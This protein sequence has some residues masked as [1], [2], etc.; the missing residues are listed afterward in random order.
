MAGDVVQTVH[1]NGGRFLR[2]QE[3][4]FWIEVPIEDA[5]AKAS[6]AL[7]ED[8]QT[9][10]KNVAVKVSNTVK[11]Q[12][13]RGNTLNDYLHAPQETAQRMAYSVLDGQ[14][15]AKHNIVTP[16]TTAIARPLQSN[17]KQPNHAEGI[18]LLPL[19]LNGIQEGVHVEHSRH[20]GTS[21]QWHVQELSWQEPPNSSNAEAKPE[22]CEQ[23][24]HAQASNFDRQD[25]DSQGSQ[26]SRD[27]LVPGGASRVGKHE[28]VAQESDAKDMS[29]SWEPPPNGVVGIVDRL[30]GVTPES[31]PRPLPTCGEQHHLAQEAAKNGQE[32]SESE[33]E[34]KEGDSHV[35]HARNDPFVWRIYHQHPAKRYVWQV[36]RHPPVLPLATK[37]EG[38][39][40]WELP[41]PRDLEFQV[42]PTRT[43][44]RCPLPPSQIFG[45]KRADDRDWV[46][47]YEQMIRFLL[48]NGECMDNPKDV[49]EDDRELLK[50]AIAQRQLYRDG[51]LDLMRQRLLEQIGF[52]WR[53]MAAGATLSSLQNKRSMVAEDDVVAAK[54]RARHDDIIENP[55]IDLSDTYLTI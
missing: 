47:M 50:W 7:R 20:I 33:N 48:M 40:P 35:S 14:P 12:L 45:G 43:S 26:A 17:D 19:M 6:Q 10:K 44:R 28:G 53:P 29:A 54:K 49:K 5:V 11:E 15:F 42:T 52:V 25:G 21:I 8:K 1:L 36:P 24:R 27:Q 31:C 55:T 23:P 32:T 39:L 16:Q 4:G 9:H 22:S 51:K 41:P 30:A 13:P 46:E 34:T 37:G 2:E 3:L 38:L 18:Q